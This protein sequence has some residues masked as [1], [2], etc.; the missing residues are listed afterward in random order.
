MSKLAEIMYDFNNAKSLKIYP[1]AGR[2]PLS[3]IAL[4]NP[5]RVVR[6]A[7]N[8]SEKEL[9]HVMDVAN[10]R[11]E[12]ITQVMKEKD[13]AIEQV[14]T[15][16]VKS[17]HHLVDE[18]FIPEYL[19]FLE[20][21]PQDDDDVRIYCKDGYSMTRFDDRWLV[22]TP[23]KTRSLIKIKSMYHAIIILEAIGIDVNV[24]D[25]LDCKYSPEVESFEKTVG[26]TIGKIIESR[27]D[28]KS[29]S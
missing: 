17:G 4:S 6:T 25:Y 29:I 7:L 21:P 27:R 3:G 23:E 11:L 14:I 9:S 5:I 22:S 13:D 20:V 26:E 2:Q 15:E 24:E 28:T 1:R 10:R 8:A 19:G 16:S 18:V 12:R